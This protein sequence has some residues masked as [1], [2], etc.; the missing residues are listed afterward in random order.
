MK[1]RLLIILFGI[2]FLLCS[3][4]S[5]AQDAELIT[6]VQRYQTGDYKNAKTLFA[7][8]TKNYST[9]DAAWY[10]LGMC[11]LYLGEIDEAQVNLK[12][13][14]DIDPKNYWYR[15]RL[16]TAYAMAGADELTEAAYEDIL[17]DFPKKN[18]A[19][20]SLV[21]LYLQNNK[22]EKALKIMDDIETIAGKSEQITMTKYEVLL[23]LDKPEEAQKVLEDFNKDYSS[24]EILTTLG[25]HAIAQYEDSTALAYY[26]EALALDR[27]F[28]P[29]LLG[30]AEIYRIRRDYT[31]YFKEMNEFMADPLIEAQDKSRYLQI[32]IQ[33][34]E[35]RFIQSF[36]SNLDSLYSTCVA[37][38]N[39]DTTVVQNAAI[40]YYSTGRQDLAKYFFKRCV[41]LSPN[42]LPVEVTYLQILGMSSSWD[43]LVEEADSAIKKFP[44]QVALYDFKT[45][46]YY[47]LGEYR[48][49]IEN[50]ETM[51]S[52]APADTAITIPCLTTLGDMYHQ[53][54]DSK[55]AYKAYDKV[56]KVRPDYSPVLNNYAYFLS[57]EGKNLKKAYSM[58]KIT[59]E[60]EPDNPTYLDT[61]GWILYLQGKALEAKPFFKHA[62]LYG[63]KDSVTILDHYAEVLYAL[64]EYDLAK[65]YW[66]QAKTKNAVSKEDPDL[67]ARIKA[68]LDAI[69]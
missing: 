42:S 48:K 37:V 62:M 18:D 69:K 51:I 41:E 39:T 49:V 52:K 15:D 10:Y 7:N 20:Y 60:K 53:L 25:D 1:S 65:S 55:N 26:N 59:V 54:G 36:R 32:L 4:P 68:R 38:H 28:S 31:N 40:Y 67:E 47:N 56:L 43:E 21:N 63:G 30:K 61:F 16:A 35:P 44:D 5:K 66:N 3:V 9:Y 57:L 45:S 2:F 50:C 17:K 33:R 6:A 12:K 58:S 29:A 34:S 19:Y 13:A 24:V 64:K 46:A 27:S 23:R 8:I 11:N 22:F 14:V